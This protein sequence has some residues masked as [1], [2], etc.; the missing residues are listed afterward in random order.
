[1]Q[2]RAAAAYGTLFLLL[3]VGAFLM[4]G[5]AEEPTVAI[6]D[7]DL[8][9][10]E[11]ESI[12]IDSRTYNETVGLQV[13]N[14]VSTTDRS[15]MLLWVNDSE[16]QTDTI[17]NK[18]EI[19]VVDVSWP[20]QTA[21]MTTTVDN[22]STV[23]Y[24]G[25][26]HT[27]VV[28]DGDFT[29]HS[30]NQTESF[31]VGDTF[32]YRNNETTVVGANGSITL[33]WGQSYDVTTQ[34]PT[35]DTVEFRETLN[36]TDRLLSDP[37]VDNDTVSRNDGREYVVYRNGTIQQLSAYLPDPEVETFEE[38]EE[39][40]YNAATDGVDFVDV[41][42]ENVSTERVLLSWQGPVDHPV[43]VENG[44][45]VSLGPNDREYVAHFPDNETLDLST[46]LGGYQDQIKRQ[47]AFWLRVN[48]LWGIT[49]LAGLAILLLLAGAYLPSRY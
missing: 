8:S 1:M 32:A 45:N 44:A 37:S 11:G 28:G 13:A 10:S 34:T 38:G 35:D 31:A 15:A 40:T 21:R 9:V 20:G 24:K 29:L 30:G 48:G 4:I 36:V 6:E 7:P 3:A 26:D 5:F 42:V 33:A 39:I 46:D 2:R 47:D 19:P 18:T 41:R 49:I 25:T 22:G 23:S 14:A 12:T 27:L 43:L 17:E 16:T